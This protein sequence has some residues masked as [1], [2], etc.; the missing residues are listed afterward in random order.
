MNTLW[1]LKKIKTNFKFYWV[2][3]IFNLK[4]QW[5]GNKFIVWLNIYFSL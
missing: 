3:I 2:C 4:L 1:R 5:A